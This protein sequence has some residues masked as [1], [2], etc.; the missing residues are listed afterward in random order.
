MSKLITTGSSK[1]IVR[2]IHTGTNEEFH[3]IP[4]NSKSFE[5]A[6][7]KAQR[8]E[9]EIYD[10]LEGLKGESLSDSEI[11]EEQFEGIEDRDAFTRYEDERFKV[12]KKE[13]SNLD[14]IK[15][16]LAE[17][18][19]SWKGMSRNQR[20]MADIEN[21]QS[22]QSADDL[23]QR[24]LQKHSD[25]LEKLHQLEANA[26]WTVD[27]KASYRA[28]LKKAIAQLSDPEGDPAFARKLVKDVEA[29]GEAQRQ[30]RLSFLERQEEHCKKQRERI[31]MEKFVLM[32]DEESQDE[33]SRLDAEVKR[34]K[35]EEE[36]AAAA[37]AQ[38][39][40]DVAAADEQL[41][42]MKQ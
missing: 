15:D 2:N 24:H 36:A 23:M 11:W 3:F 1:L 38:N 35:A 12:V 39:L 19:D 26:R 10:H 5:I 8:R 20:L 13:R 21:M 4:Q 29:H 17:D 40:Q 25:T 30:E 22:R 16:Q 14:K 42:R 33:I 28:A 32:A 18:D 6:R 7:S 9:R 34:L 41:A 27:A 31:S 37:V